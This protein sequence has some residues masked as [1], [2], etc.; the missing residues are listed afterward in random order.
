MTIPIVI[1]LNLSNYV[2]SGF[3]GVIPVSDKE[4][5]KLIEKEHRC[6]HK[7]GIAHIH[8]DGSKDEI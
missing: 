5:L 6:L 8:L 7:E 1:D 3:G 4:R 2:S